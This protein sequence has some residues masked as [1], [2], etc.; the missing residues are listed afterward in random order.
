MLYIRVIH[1]IIPILEFTI[2]IEDIL[3]RGMNFGNFR[4]KLSSVGKVLEE[5][6][7]SAAKAGYALASNETLLCFTCSTSISAAQMSL[8][9]I[10]YEQCR[11]CG[12]KFCGKCISKLT[13][14]NSIPKDILYRDY[15]DKTAIVNWVCTSCVPILKL[16]W[17]QIF[18]FDYWNEVDKRINEYFAGN[19]RLV[20]FYD[21]PKPSE[22]SY[23]RQV[24]RFAQVAE[25]VAD[26]VGYKFM[27]R[28]VKYA[29]YSKELYAML[30]AGDILNV[31]GPVAGELEKLGARKLGSKGVL[32]LYYLSCIH[33][34]ELK[35]NP[36]IEFSQ[37]GDVDCPESLL[38]LIGK[39]TDFS[40]FLY[41]AALPKPHNSPEWTSWYLANLVRRQ[42]WTVVACVGETTKLLNDH[43]CPAFALLLR[44]GGD[45]SS[46]G[47]GSGSGDNNFSDLLMQ[48]SANERKKQRKEAVLVVR[49]SKG[50][51]DWSINLS[52]DPTEF[53]YYQ[54]CDNTTP[55]VGLGTLSANLIV[56]V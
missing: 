42:Q 26:M 1:P 48:G 7:T 54:G 41:S 31:L 6:A 20:K 19:E 4:E 36:D 8:G 50:V 10:T 56:S 24:E 18:Q 22:D 55:V 3:K 23:T 21:I 13:L 53:T 11:I 16:R 46:S 29:Y 49:G 52:E 5:S 34:L 33:K 30:L 9:I 37:F 14:E 28:A 32:Q 51:M 12:K 38:D 43:K 44:G 27:F 17:M 39:Y 47:S 45:G 25:I 40:Q 35:I 15:T 2:I